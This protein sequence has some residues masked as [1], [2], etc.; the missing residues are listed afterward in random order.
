MGTFL[1]L[2]MVL[3]QAPLQTVTPPQT[4]RV[5][6]AVELIHEQKYE[7]AYNVLLELVKDDPTNARAFPFLAAMQLQTGRL[8]D[9]EKNIGALVAH[10]PENAD[11]RELSGQ[12]YMARRNWKKAEEQWRWIV[13]QRPNSEQGHMQLAAV[14]LQED[15]Y[16]D[17]LAEVTRS[18][19]ISPKRSDARSLRGNIL[20]T[21]G[22]INQAALDWN[23]AL[24]G[25]PDDTVALSGLAVFLRQ[26]D[27][28]RALKYA[29]RA[30]ELTDWKSLGPMR[31]LAMVYRARREDD[32][33]RKV[34]GRAQMAFPNNEALAAEMRG[35]AEAPSAARNAPAETK[36]AEPAKVTT[37]PPTKS[38]STVAVAPPAA[39]PPAPP[40]PTSV[41]VVD[42]PPAP[43]DAIKLPPLAAGGLTLGAAVGDLLAFDRLPLPPAP[44]SASTPDSPP[45]AKSKPADAEPTA[46]VVVP[47]KPPA[48][49]TE[50]SAPPAVTVA[51]PPPTKPSAPAPARE[52]VPSPSSAR[53]LDSPSISLASISPLAFGGLT[54]GAAFS[55]LVALEKLPSPPPQATNAPT[56]A[57]PA[58]PLIPAPSRLS[59]PKIDLH[60][61]MIPLSTIS[62]AFVYGEVP[63]PPAAARRP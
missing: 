25:D 27:P 42:A 10:D 49:P 63:P 54:L 8:D 3:A 53:A 20:A 51:A 19:E 60:W 29:S 28:D 30:V 6:H 14:L 57:P 59:A 22:Q 12:L 9:A 62:P 18:L 26:T 34:L 46:K 36:K 44:A 1:I 33:A 16:N 23:I 58:P 11:L 13:A 21:L 43:P 50:S 39:K 24:V 41:R 2:A 61:G 32:L 56:A 35:D 5:D 17:A 7:M 52:S 38:T 15:R 55:D 40:V 47:S 37:A 4:D 48:K 31:V 45:P